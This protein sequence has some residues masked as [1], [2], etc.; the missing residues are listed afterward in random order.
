MCKQSIDKEIASSLTSLVL[1]HFPNGG[2]YLATYVV[3]C[4]VWMKQQ[5]GKKKRHPGLK[6][7][8]AAPFPHTERLTQKG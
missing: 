6:L 7:D 3:G 2:G 4:Q 8:G 1:G 5:Q